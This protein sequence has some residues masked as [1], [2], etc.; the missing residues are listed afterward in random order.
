MPVFKLWKTKEFGELGG[1]IS[2]KDKMVNFRCCFT[3][4]NKSKL[5]SKLEK[6]CTVCE[7]QT[8]LVNS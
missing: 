8:K 6:H 4:K 2:E 1:V 5:F 3:E 7:A